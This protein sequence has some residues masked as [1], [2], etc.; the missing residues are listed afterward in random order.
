MI[1]FTVLHLRHPQ[2]YGPT[3]TPSSSLI[4]ALVLRFTGE[5]SGR[6]DSE[7]RYA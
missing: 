1:D 3:M 5:S 6:L 7:L 2:P 4:A